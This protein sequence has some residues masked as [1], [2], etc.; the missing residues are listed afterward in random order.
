MKPT[1]A[2]D[3]EVYT[4]YTLLLFKTV[5]EPT[6]VY[7]FE[8][9][10]QTEGLDEFQLDGLRTLVTSHRL[11]TFNGNGYDIPLLHL[12]LR[13][14]PSTKIKYASDRII[15]QGLK[16]W[17]FEK[18]FNVNLHEGM[19]DTIDLM[20]V[21]PLT[22]SLKNYAAKMHSKSIQDLPLAPSALIQ[23]DQLPLMRAY[24]EHDLDSTTDLFRCLE[25]PLALREAMSVQYGVDLRSKSD[26]QIAEAVI[27]AEVEK[28]TGRKL[29]KPGHSPGDKFK[30][31]VPSWMGFTMTDIL[32]AISQADFVVTDTGGVLMPDELRLRKIGIG[33]GVYRMGIGG[34]HSSE[35]KQIAQADESYMLIDF[36]VVSYYPS[37]LLNQRLYPQHIGPV[38]LEVYQG[39]VN[40]RLAAKKIKARKSDAESLK[41]TINGTFG[42]LGSK[43]SALYSPD[44]MI[45]VTVTGQLALLMLIETLADLVGVEVMSANTDGV[46]IRCL[47]ESEAEAVAATKV[48]EARTGFELERADYAALYNRDVNS[49]IAVKTNGEVKTKGEYGAGLPLHKTPAGHICSTA[50]IE[51]LTK[52]TPIVE[53]IGRCTD[54]REFICARRVTGGAVWR[55][56]EIG[57]IVRWIYSTQETEAFTYKVSKITVPKT[58]GAFPLVTLPDQIPDHLDYQWYIDE[59]A[60]MLDDLGVTI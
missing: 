25:Q 11:I 45:Q 58:L 32:P 47:R 48:W 2:F 21:A 3:M 12:A 20:D 17:N 23:E 51:Y 37:I 28:I 34:L 54:V 53:T 60:S 52:G 31:Q 19:I 36:D 33:A 44:L 57:R 59:A 43:W 42:K 24:C 18:E 29:E 38:F 1:L 10:N 49:Y 7:P 13:G 50:V 40:A 8:L 35:K 56:Q 6:L 26:A 27:K 16:W 5:G 39:I 22:G 15:V 9:F 14:E 55:G 30:Y 41:I 4:N 46:T